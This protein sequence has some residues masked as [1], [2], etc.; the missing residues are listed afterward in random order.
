M[1][2]TAQTSRLKYNLEHALVLDH[3]VE[4]VDEHP[5]P[6]LALQLEREA[7]TRRDPISVDS[8]DLDEEQ[9]LFATALAAIQAAR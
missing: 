2:N 9:I 1:K 4:E 6:I 7:V 5:T 8:T 3:I